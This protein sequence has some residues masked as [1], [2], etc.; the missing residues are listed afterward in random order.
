M[1][2]LSLSVLVNQI[3][4][5]K[6]FTYDN[7]GNQ[8]TTQITTP[9]GSKS[10]AIENKYDAY[11]QLIESKTSKGITKNEYNAE[12]YR[13]IKTVGEESTYYLYEADKII[14]EADKTGKQTAKNT[15]GLNLLTRTVDDKTYNYMYNGHADVTALIEEETGKISATYYYDAFGNITE[16]TGEVN[17]NIKYAGYQHDE[18]T[19]LYYLIQFDK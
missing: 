14:L 10:L 18:E 17:N 5:T 1:S 12:G 2:F 7:N 6:I 11:N 9:T 19:G 16:K 13:T 4:D 15:Y 3:Q 8:L